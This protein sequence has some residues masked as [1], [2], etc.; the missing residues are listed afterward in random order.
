MMARVDCC[1]RGVI[2]RKGLGCFC[3]GM[4]LKNRCF[5]NYKNK[6]AANEKQNKCNAMHKKTHQTNIYDMTAVILF[7][8]R[9]TK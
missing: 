1:V 9:D 2:E 8:V 4:L 6:K 7:G 5:G 3:V